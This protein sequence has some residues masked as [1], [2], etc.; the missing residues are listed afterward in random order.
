MVDVT[1]GDAT[2]LLLVVWKPVLE[3]DSASI[4][5]AGCVL[6]ELVVVDDMSPGAV[7]LTAA[8]TVELLNVWVDVLLLAVVLTAALAVT[9]AVVLAVVLVW[10]L[11]VV[12]VVLLVVVI[13]VSL[14]LLLAVLLAMLRVVLLVVLLTAL[15]V[16]F[17]EVPV[18]VTVDMLVMDA[19]VVDVL[20]DELL[21]VAVVL[22]RTLLLV[23]GVRVLLVMIALGGA[24]TMPVPVVVLVGFATTSTVVN[25]V[26]EDVKFG[27]SIAVVVVGH[28]IASTVVS[29]VELI[30]RDKDT[31]LDVEADVLVTEAGVE[32]EV[33]RLSARKHS[34]PTSGMAMSIGDIHTS[35]RWKTRLYSMPVHTERFMFV[36]RAL[37]SSSETML[38]STS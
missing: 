27:G 29:V 22:L 36:Q 25:V 18:D 12:L 9:L 11:A 14:A 37:H 30:L 33:V 32:V 34:N 21:R 2:E 26:L 19:V 4:W 38:K 3:D 20:L 7:L 28:T 6:R 8:V 35:Q 5:L 17:D 13:V 1:F 24:L 15:V 16:V 31:V 23:E 10:L